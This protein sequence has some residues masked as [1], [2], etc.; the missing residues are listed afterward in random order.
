APAL[1]GGAVR[2]Q[3]LIREVSRDVDVT[4]VSLIDTPA[5]AEAAS[6]ATLREICRDVVLVP[7]DVHA[8]GGVLEPAKTRGFHSARLAEI[9]EDWLD[10]RRFDVVQVEYTHMAHFLP[11]PCSGMLRVLVEHDVTFVAA[12]RARARTEG[13][14]RRALLWLDEQKTFRHE[15][16][17]ARFADRTIAMSDDDRAVLA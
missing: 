15:I 16:L 7:R 17:A 10:R 8:G 13:R 3:N 1:H 11:P 12:A 14:L 2:M 9:V 5:E 4:L 6:L